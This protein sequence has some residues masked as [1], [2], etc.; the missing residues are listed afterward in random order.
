MSVDAENRAAAM[1]QC[2]AGGCGRVGS[3]GLSGMFRVGPLLNAK[4]TNLLQQLL[5]LV[6]FITSATTG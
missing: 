4:T 2:G 1:L 5:V 6:I 3:L